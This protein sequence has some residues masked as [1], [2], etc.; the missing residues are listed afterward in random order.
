MPGSLYRLPGIVLYKQ[1][2]AKPVGKRRSGSDEAEK[3]SF[4]KTSKG[5]ARRRKS[6]Q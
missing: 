2:Q 1:P 3:T 4:V 5:N 6:H